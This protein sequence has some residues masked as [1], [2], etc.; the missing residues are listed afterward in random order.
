MAV[1]GQH[2]SASDREAIKADI[3]NGVAYGAIR[4]KWGVATE[5]MTRLRREVLAESSS[6]PADG[7]LPPSEPTDPVATRREVHDAAFWRTK[8]AGLAKSL[9]SAE[10]VAEELAGI[11]GV[12]IRVPNWASPVSSSRRGRSVIGCLISDVHMGEV[13]E[14]GEIQGIN[15]FTPDICRAR[16]RRYFSAVCE[17]G[18]RWASDT[19]C[20][21]AMVALA[22]DLI[23][24]DIH[25]ELRVTNALTSHEQVRAVVEEAVFGINLLR[26]AFGK[27]HVVGVPGNHGRTTIKPTAKMYSRLSYDTLAVSMVADRF[28]GDER[29]SF[30]FGEAKDQVTPIYGR[31]VLT[32]HGDKI[33]T[34][35]GMGFAGPVLPIVRGAKKIEAQQASVGRRPHLIQFGHYHT[36]SNP[37]DVLSNGSVP[38]YSEYADDLRASVEPPQQWAYLLHSKWFMRERMPIQL[39]EPAKPRVQAPSVSFG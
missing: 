39:E 19:D 36:T 21:G 7:I 4:K 37:G 27:V 8:S 9:A 10:H 13:I 22:G 15:A 29:V 2:R 17:I 32:T 28:R 14:P 11:R 38:G 1:S 6:T 3:R 24:G 30:Q 25:E 33:G 26:E 12:E 34:R 5:T 23:S 20:D 31:S 18:S 35:G 16:L